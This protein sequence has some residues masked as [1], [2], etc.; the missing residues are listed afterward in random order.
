MDLKINQISLSVTVDLKFI[1]VLHHQ[2]L[3]IEGMQSAG[4]QKDNQ[5]TRSTGETR[6]IKFLHSVS[7]SEVVSNTM[8]Y[9]MFQWPDTGT[10][11]LKSR[12]SCQHESETAA[13]S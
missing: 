1:R 12:K 4:L 3:S 5:E 8:R 7:L 11:V 9:V 10:P 6:I 13:G 2:G